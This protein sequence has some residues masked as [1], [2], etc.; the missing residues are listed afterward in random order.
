LEGEREVNEENCM[1][2]R[3][4]DFMKGK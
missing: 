1:F 2:F 4:S 3:G